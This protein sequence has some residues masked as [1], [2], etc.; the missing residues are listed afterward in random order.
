MEE[1]YLEALA[2]SIENYI[3]GLTNEFFDYFLNNEKFKDIST[4]IQTLSNRSKEYR[5]PSFLT[6]V[7][8]PVKSGKSTLVNLFANAY[9]SP[10]HFLECTVRPSFISRKLADEEGC[11]TIYKSLNSENKAEQIETIIDWLNG[12][13]DGSDIS[14]VEQDKVDL[15]RDN[16]E[17]YVRLDLVKINQD[18]ALMTSIKTIGGKLLCEN[19]FIVDM[20]GFDGA[21]VNLSESPIYAKIVE[22]ADLIIFVQSSNS[23]ISKVSSDF[24]ELLKQNNPSA[25]V[26]LIHNIF[27]SAYWRD[28]EEICKNIIKQ[29]NYALKNIQMRGITISDANAYNINLGKVSDF[30]EHKYKSEEEIVLGKEEEEFKKIEESIYELLLQQRGAIRMKNCINRTNIQKRYLEKILSTELKKSK[31]IEEKYEKTIKEFDQLK[32]FPGLLNITTNIKLD[33][34]ELLKIVGEKH[35]H[36]CNS[37]VNQYRPNFAREEIMRF[38]NTTR[39]K[40]IDTIKQDFRTLTKEIGNDKNFK[41]WIEEIRQII[42]KYQITNIPSFSTLQQDI[43]VDFSQT[44]VNIEILAPDFHP[45]LF[46]RTY[47]KEYM[48]DLLRIVKE[49]I[50]NYITDSFFP[51][52]QTNWKETE[53]S[54]YEKITNEGNKVI[55]DAKYKALHKIL[56]DYEQFMAENRILDTIHSKLE[57]INIPTI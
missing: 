2:E 33:L 14:E 21:N 27:E 38:F 11:I 49:E 43:K 19:V 57:D 20:A 25:P 28:N 1:E 46:F 32:K 40:I 54:I 16:I 56:P 36:A 26:C 42:N 52:V 48:E 23:A 13:T 7:V 30:R 4:A 55:E 9:V 47:S 18:D 3:Q 5:N 50:E 15:N 51:T 29:K 31:C 37:L 6:L 8:G 45:I 12:L 53:K 10:T 24:F 44:V 35:N 34:N 39:D 17:K 41:Y 22:R